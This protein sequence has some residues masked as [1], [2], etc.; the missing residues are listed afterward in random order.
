[1]SPKQQQNNAQRSKQSENAYNVLA[2]LPHDGSTPTFDGRDGKV[3]EVDG[4]F[5]GKPFQS[6]VLAGSPVL[7]AST[8]QLPMT[9]QLVEQYRAYAARMDH[10]RNGSK[11]TSDG[12]DGKGDGVDG[13]FTGKA[14]QCVV[15]AGSPAPPASTPQQQATAEQSRFSDYHRSCVSAIN[16]AIAVDDNYATLDQLFH[17]NQAEFTGASLLG[18]QQIHRDTQRRFNTLDDT[19]RNNSDEMRHRFDVMMTKFNDLLFENP[20]LRK[21]YNSTRAETA[22]LKA[23]VDALMKK[24]NEQQQVIS[25]P[26]APNLTASSSAMDLFIYLFI[27]SYTHP[28]VRLWRNLQ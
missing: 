27:N 8:Q 21:A 1:M 17:D 16:K 5:A 26:P 20:T 4:N 13:N 12:S 18:I 24:I 6:V 23:A 7:S 11:P 14:S 15:P 9:Q 2:D 19:I 10:Y 25:A 3:D 28:T 22:A